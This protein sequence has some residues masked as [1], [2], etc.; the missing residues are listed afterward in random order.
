MTNRYLSRIALVAA[1]VAVSSSAAWGKPASRRAVDVVQPDG[2]TVAVRTIGDAF[3]HYN[4]TSDGYPVIY[5]STLGTVYAR[6]HADGQIE[7]TEI[8]AHN[9]GTRLAREVQFLSTLTNDAEELARISSAARK[10][11]RGPGLKSDNFPTKGKQRA[12]VLLVE[13]QDMRFD[14]YNK[15]KYKYT[16]YSDS[17]NPVHQYWYDMLNLEGFNGFGGTGSCRD[18]F[19]QNSADA[20]GNPQ[21]DPSFD[22]FGPVTLPDN[23]EVY[24]RNDNY[25]NDINPQKMVIDACHLLDDQVDFSIYDTNG[26][27]EVDNIFIFYA[28]YGE[29]DAGS[30]YPDTIWPHSWDLTKNDEE[31]LLDGVRINH[32][33]CSNETDYFMNRPDGIGTF[34]HE[35]SHVL[36]LPDLYATEKNVGSY[37]PGEYSVLDYGPYNNNGRTPPNYSAYE[38]YALDWLTPEEYDLSGEYE[39]GNLADTN[40]AYIVRTAQ[41]NEYFLIE[42]RQQSGW[43]IYLPG[44]GMMIWHVDYDPAVFKQNIVNNKP[45]HQH[46]DLVEA[47][48]RYQSKYADGHTFPGTNSVTTYSFADWNRKDCGVSFSDISESNGIIYKTVE[49]TESGIAPILPALGKD[50]MGKAAIYNLQGIPVSDPRPGDI[51][52]CNGRKVIVPRN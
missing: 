32:Y 38:R 48:K 25:N 6:F 13:F 52:I 39:L 43:D 21:F 16:T 49:V 27:G 17:E 1:I 30:K 23:M 33:A 51:V 4:I 15:D 41:S 7:A 14:A 31:F 19:V 36:G 42:N 24:G 20:D 10:V 3:H 46:V 11:R 2:T 47:N 29:A 50:D 37:T 34:V 22:L 45:K 35:F 28:G 44:H 26:D 8:L 18:W 9:P 12:L 40:K 5:D